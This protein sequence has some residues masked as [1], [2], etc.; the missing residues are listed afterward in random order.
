MV[1]FVT[2]LAPITT[3]ISMG[4]LHPEKNPGLKHRFA[5]PL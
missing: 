3:G 5:Y 4:D 1:G 2:G